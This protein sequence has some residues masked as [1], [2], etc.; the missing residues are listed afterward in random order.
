MRTEVIVASL[1]S[2]TSALENLD[3]R[4]CAVTKMEGPRGFDGRDGRDGKDGRDGSDGIDGRDGKDAVFDL[5][6]VE[7][8][9]QTLLDTRS[10]LEFEEVN[11][12]I[13]AL[14]DAKYS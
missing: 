2:I 10:A 1:E 8:T 3:S 6:V 7:A 14:H 9:L 13:Q 11:A 4:V 12:A 5:P